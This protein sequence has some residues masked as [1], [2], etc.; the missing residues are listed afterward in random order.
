[1][2]GNT[3]LDRIHHLDLEDTTALDKGNTDRRDLLDKVYTDQ[4]GTGNKQF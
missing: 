4:E 1:M 2:A 3:K